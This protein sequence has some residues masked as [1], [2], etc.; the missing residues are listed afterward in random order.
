MALRICSLSSGSSGNCI[1]V[2]SDTTR[3]LIDAGIPSARIE[4]CLRVLGGAA[5][6][7]SILVTHAHSDHVSNLAA[8]SKKTGAQVYAHHLSET[9]VKKRGSFA[10]TAFGKEAFNVGDIAVTPFSLPHDAPCV[11]F[12]LRSGRHAVSVL[13][14]LGE[15]SAA[16]IREISSSDVVLIEANHD[17]DLLRGGPYPHYLKQRVL[18]RQGHLSNEACA[19]ACA[20]IVKG[21]VKQIMLGHLSRENNSPE[22][23][24]SCVAARL[25]QEGLVEGRDVSLEVAPSFHMSGLYEVI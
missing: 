18:S 9:D 3:I 11:G 2:A 12:T 24:F 7:L 25:K 19:Q 15:A 6:N 14:D 1:Y 22:R 17:E 4:K 13:T 20:Q 16:V 5:D 10:L 23:A 21:R 8:F